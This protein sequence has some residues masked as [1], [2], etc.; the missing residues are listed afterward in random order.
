MEDGD[1]E[2]FPPGTRK[3]PQARK[4]LQQKEPEV[5]KNYTAELD[6]LK[7]K[8]RIEPPTLSDSEVRKVLNS[9]T[10]SIN[11][12]GIPKLSQPPQRVLVLFGNVCIDFLENNCKEVGC[13]NSHSLPKVEEMREKFERCALKPV[14]DAFGAALLY[15]KVLDQFF[16]VFAEMFVKK[17]PNELSRL[18]RMIME[19]ERNARSH[20]NYRII[21][22]ALIKFGSKSKFEAVKFIVTH[23]TD[24]KYSRDILMSLIAETGPDIVRFVTYLQNVANQQTISAASFDKILKTVVSYQSPDILTFCLNNLL[25][26][27]PEYIR[28]LKKENVK[29]F[30]DIQTYLTQFNQE[31]EEKLLSV[32]PKI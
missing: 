17:S 28:Q 5:E 1:E 14:D 7:M 4:D 23:H 32:L 25:T 31:R 6:E 9:N 12:N 20:Q 24:S 16:S 22:D 27:N 11:M 13:K 10:Q 3:I 29:Q 8:V 19:C 30:L 15:P 2:Y 18:S 26:H 21:V